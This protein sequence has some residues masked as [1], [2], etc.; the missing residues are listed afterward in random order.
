LFSG[1]KQWC[2]VHVIKRVR[3]LLKDGETVAAR[4]VYG[5]NQKWAKLYIRIH[6]SCKTEKDDAGCVSHETN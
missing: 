2:L 4:L 3:T 1:H 6:D 5:A